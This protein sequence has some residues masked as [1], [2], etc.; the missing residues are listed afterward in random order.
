MANERECFHVECE[1]SKSLILIS[2]QT[3][4]TEYQRIGWS[5]AQSC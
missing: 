1:D 4:Q 5:Y 2:I 3:Q